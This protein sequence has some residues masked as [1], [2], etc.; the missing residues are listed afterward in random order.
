MA[1]TRFLI[2]TKCNPLNDP[3]GG[4]ASITFHSTAPG[5]VDHGHPRWSCVWT[6]WTNH[7]SNRNLQSR[8]VPKN[9]S[10]EA[11]LCNMRRLARSR[12][13]ILRHARMC[14]WRVRLAVRDSQLSLIANL[15][16]EQENTIHIP[17]NLITKQSSLSSQCHIAPSVPS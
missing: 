1:A 12:D 7:S 13:N 2:P 4:I 14:Y 17:V 15:L 3:P 9:I 10:H 16:F 6:C 11:P 5:V 8:L